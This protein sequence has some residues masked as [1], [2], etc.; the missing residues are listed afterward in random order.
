MDLKTDG[1]QWNNIF[2]PWLIFTHTLWHTQTWGSVQLNIPLLIKASQ[3]LMA[4]IIQSILTEE[5]T[6][7]D[8]NE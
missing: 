3:K 4:D 7:A 2:I 6:D 8:L 1:I 5:Q